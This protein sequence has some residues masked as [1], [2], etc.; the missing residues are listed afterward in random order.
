MA[1]SFH[2]DDLVGA[3]MMTPGYLFRT[4]AG[5]NGAGASIIAP[6]KVAKISVLGDFFAFLL[7][8]SGGGMMAMGLMALMGQNITIVGLFI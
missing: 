4:V 5:P 1:W 6:G 2:H 8:A 3:I 7:Q